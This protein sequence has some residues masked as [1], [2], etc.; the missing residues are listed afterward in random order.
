MTHPIQIEPNALN[1]K[2]LYTLL[3][4]ASHHDP[5]LGMGAN[6]NLYRRQ[7]VRLPYHA[8]GRALTAEWHS[9]IADAFPIPIDC[10]DLFMDEP[11]ER[12]IGIALLKTFIENYERNPEGDGWGQG[13]FTGVEAYTRLI[14]RCE[15]AAPRA[16][17]LKEFWAILVKDLQVTHL[18]ESTALFKILGVPNGCH[19]EV[20]Y[21]IAK[22]AAML[23]EMA[24]YWLDTEKMAVPAYAT[25]AK[26]PQASTE[27]VTLS[28]VDTEAVD[29][30]NMTMLESSV[31]VPVHSGND[32]R[33]DIRYAGMVHLFATLGLDLTTELPTS[34][35][36][37]FENGGNIA[38]GK[39]APTTAYALS[40]EI[41]E[42]YPIL[43]LMGGCVDGFMLGD[44]N[45][46]AVSAFWAGREF[47]AALKSLFGITVSHSVTDM[48][49]SWTLHRHVGRYDGSPMP[50]SFETVAAGAELYVNFQLSPWTPLLEQGAFWA[51][52]QTF[53]DIDGHIGGQA[54]KG[55]GKVRVDFLQADTDILLSARELYES[56][57]R[58]HASELVFG[59]KNGT[60]GTTHKVCST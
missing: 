30:E 22:Y 29:A 4:P 46:Q 39:S 18:R 26:K 3:E 14:A 7:R 33:H 48:L 20:L 44:S 31:A 8:T 27:Q 11:F 37:L 42:K 49:D 21:H 43:G 40:Q 60:L 59:L 58:E 35:K 56:H 54:A 9:K 57:L 13:L 6:V 24:R 45:L 41:R 52:L 32:I 5:T 10:Q 50:Y 36:A 28:F 19:H 25:K 53:I 47:N 16:V 2:C 17:N 12:F 38:K 15:L 23:V 55:F 1:I 34:V 51:A